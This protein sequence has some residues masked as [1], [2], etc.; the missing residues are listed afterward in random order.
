VASLGGDPANLPA[1]LIIAFAALGLLFFFLDKR[2][3]W[4]HVVIAQYWTC[5][6]LVDEIRDLVLAAAFW[7]LYRRFS[8][9]RE[10]A[11][12]T[13]SLIASAIAA[14]C[15]GID[16]VWRLIGGAASRSY[17]HGA[18]WRVFL[19]AALYAAVVAVALAAPKPRQR[20][21]WL[22]A[23]AGGIGLVRVVAMHVWSAMPY[24]VDY[25]LYTVYLLVVLAAGILMYRQRPLSDSPE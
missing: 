10:I 22:L 25:V 18:S 5:N 24:Q 4:T 9:D 15:A 12:A 23:I 7:L 16:L 19:F 20:W 21:S 14:L 13:T 6:A 11:S 17:V 3:S 2:T 8:A 1:V